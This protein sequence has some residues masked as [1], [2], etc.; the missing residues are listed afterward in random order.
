[1]PGKDESS[2]PTTD[3]WMPRWTCVLSYHSSLV[4]TLTLSLPPII[5]EDDH[6]VF[7]FPRGLREYVC[8]PEPSGEMHAIEGRWHMS[9][10]LTEQGN[11]VWTSVKLRL[12]CHCE[13]YLH[14]FRVSSNTS[15][16]HGI[17]IFVWGRFNPSHRSVSGTASGVRPVYG[18]SRAKPRRR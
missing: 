17:S 8:A 2:Y 5:S 9:I 10:S 6:E 14:G 18:T 3:A 13:I 15:N 11:W 12:P 1:M 4:L 7:R 16:K